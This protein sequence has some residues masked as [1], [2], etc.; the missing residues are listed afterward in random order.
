[1]KKTSRKKFGKPT[2]DDYEEG[3][4]TCNNPW[5]TG[6]NFQEKY[7]EIHGDVVECVD[8]GPD[9]MDKTNPILKT[10]KKKTDTPPV[11][12]QKTATPPATSRKTDTPPAG[13]RKKPDKSFNGDQ[14]KLDTSAL[15][16]VNNPSK[17]F[18][19]DSFNTTVNGDV[20]S[21]NYASEWSY[22]QN[23]VS[24]VQNDS[25]NMSDFNGDLSGCNGDVSDLNGDLSALNICHTNYNDSTKEQK[26]NKY[27][28]RCSPDEKQKMN[29][30]FSIPPAKKNIYTFKSI[31]QIDDSPYSDA[32]DD[33]TKPFDEYRV[34]T[35]EFE[36]DDSEIYMTSVTDK[37]H[38]GGVFATAA[39]KSTPPVE[40]TPNTDDNAI[41]NGWPVSHSIGDSGKRMINRHLNL[42]TRPKTTT[43][44][45]S[46]ITADNHNPDM[47]EFPPLSSAKLETNG[48]SPSWNPLSSTKWTPNPTAP[49]FTRSEPSKSP[50]TQSLDEIERS[51][52]PEYDSAMSGVQRRPSPQTSKQSLGRGKTLQFLATQS[53]K[54][55]FKKGFLEESHQSVPFPPDEELLRVPLVAKM[56]EDKPILGETV[57]ILKKFPS[58]LR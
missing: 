57:S 32:C 6:V 41:I 51:Q 3:E 1:M 29:D 25:S 16:M 35:S 40:K 31:R 26:Q 38:R 53:K 13:S 52:T 2:D 58:P 50:F 54:Q 14:S 19:D 4:E 10:T 8:Y 45:A 47:N 56:V 49:A 30:F 46:K 5:S 55:Q 18:V 21:D 44:L 36:S 15:S 28:Q 37:P 12:S 42:S 48:S 20:T 7:H 23:D 24:D 22:L 11:S 39:K 9:L 34:S 27:P 33:N 17:S 43:P